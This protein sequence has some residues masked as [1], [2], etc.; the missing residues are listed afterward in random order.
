MEDGHIADRKRS[1]DAGTYLLGDG[2]F[3]HRCCG[4]DVQR[5]IKVN[6]RRIN[7]RPAVWINVIVP[8]PD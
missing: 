7:E 1:T 2:S 3:F 8:Q 4:D 5:I 6:T